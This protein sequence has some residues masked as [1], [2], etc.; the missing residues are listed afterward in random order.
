MNLQ[1]RKMLFIVGE[2]RK[3]TSPKNIIFTTNILVICENH[4]SG[5]LIIFQ[6]TIKDNPPQTSTYQGSDFW[7][8]GE[9]D[10]IAVVV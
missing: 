8:S 2:V 3:N 4:E 9:I 6:V 1:P 5:C 7:G 10:Q